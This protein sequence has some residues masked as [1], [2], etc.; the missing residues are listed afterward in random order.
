MHAKKFKARVLETVW[1]TPNVITIRFEPNRDFKFES[2]QFLS[3][4]VPNAEDPSHPIRRAYSFANSHEEALKNGYEICAKYHPTGL[5]TNYLRS[6]KPGDIFEATAPY[7]DFYYQIPEAG[8][9]VC[10]IATG[11]GIAPFRSILTSNAFKE[12][13]PAHSLVLFGVRTDNE[14]LYQSTFESLK[15]PTRFCISQASPNSSHFSGRVTD[16]LRTLPVDWQW[17]T[18]DFYICGNSEMIQEI[19]QILIGGHGVKETA[20]F[21]EAFFSNQIQANASNRS[22]PIA[23]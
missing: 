17:H 7:G 11:T 12:N 20:I 8:R 1:L 13:P 15:V 4:F 22:S 6:L 5:G 9:G 18:T 2:G 23:A 3:L 16:F 21:Q 19:R 10:F 14:V